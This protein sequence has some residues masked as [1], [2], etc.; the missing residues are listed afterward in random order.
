M[1]EPD[2]IQ[3][4]V[5]ITNF[6]KEAMSKLANGNHLSS[7]DGFQSL[8]EAVMSMIEAYNGE[9]DSLGKAKVLM[10]DVRVDLD[11]ARFICDEPDMQIYDR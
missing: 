8:H 9:K 1:H 2:A 3:T 11:I 7:V 4:K 6:I 10:D 5:E